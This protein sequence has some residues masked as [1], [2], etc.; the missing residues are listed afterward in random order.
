MS[1]TVVD[2]LLFFNPQA[3]LTPT[4]RRHVSSLWS[5]YWNNLPVNLPSKFKSIELNILNKV[6]VQKLNPV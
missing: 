2:S 1:S 5:S 4:L 6:L 3:D